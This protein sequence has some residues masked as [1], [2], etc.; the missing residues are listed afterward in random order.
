[1][2]DE[3][4]GHYGYQQSCNHPPAVAENDHSCIAGSFTDDFRRR[5]TAAN[6]NLD[7]S[8]WQRFSRCT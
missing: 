6:T 3:K 1:M 4:G 7:E 5:T 8:P 2:S